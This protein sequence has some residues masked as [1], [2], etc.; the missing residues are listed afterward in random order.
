MMHFEDAD[1]DT[2]DHAK[3]KEEIIK[4]LQKM[5]VSEADTSELVLI[6][7]PGSIMVQIA[8]P[9]GPVE[10]VCHKPL[11]S[12]K[13]MGHSPVILSSPIPVPTEA[14]TEPQEATPPPHGKAPAPSAPSAAKSASAPA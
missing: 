13:V 2:T 7:A 3:F 5:G 11:A 12:M 1:Y 4:G 8:G 6:L 14:P 9:A 10:R